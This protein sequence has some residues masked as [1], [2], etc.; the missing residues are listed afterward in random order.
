MRVYT[1]L[2]VVNRNAVGHMAIEIE[3]EYLSFNPNRK[4]DAEELWNTLE[5][6]KNGFGKEADVII[7]VDVDRI[8]HPYILDT[9]N[10]SGNYYR[11]LGGYHYNLYK[12]NCCHVVGSFMSRAIFPYL[13]SIFGDSGKDDYWLKRES[14]NCYARLKK[15]N[16]LY[17]K[18]NY[19]STH[20]SISLDYLFHWQEF[21]M[22]KYAIYYMYGNLAVQS[23][24]NSYSLPDD[25]W[26]FLFNPSSFTRYIAYA[27]AVVEDLSG[28][29][30][31]IPWIFDY[32]QN[33]YGQS[34]KREIKS[35]ERQM[36]GIKGARL[37]FSRLTGPLDLSS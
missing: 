37:R 25:Q 11:G 28:R 6:D 17:F 9:F 3:N 8:F 12:N 2:P 32:E 15:I 10:P 1:W 5:Q 21:E 13:V 30:P 34:R 20:N 24:A 16:S 35:F 36:K 19:D 29:V 26:F 18:Y 33:D 4:S 7:D 23:I 27:K 31:P 14:I 22:H